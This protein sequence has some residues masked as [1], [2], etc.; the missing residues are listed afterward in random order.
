MGKL[1]SGLGKGA[2]YISNEGYK[3]QFIKKFGF[4]PYPGTLNLRLVRE[5]IRKKKLIEACPPIMIKGFSNGTQNFGA[6]KCWR[7]LVNEKVEGIVVLAARTRYGTDVIEIISPN[8]LRDKLILKDG[9]EVKI[10]ILN[11]SRSSF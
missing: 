3:K 11:P 9:D 8:D 4:D 10:T 1:F 7:A 2:Y 5:D 6:V